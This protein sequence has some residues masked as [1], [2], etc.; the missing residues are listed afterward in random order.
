MT[1]YHV[2][3]T[4]TPTAM[5]VD[6]D[7]TARVRRVTVEISPWVDLDIHHAIVDDALGPYGG[8]SCAS[9]TERVNAT[10]LVATYL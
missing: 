6:I 4:T 1:P 2:D 10:T 5:V 8:T 7:D 9:E 3:H